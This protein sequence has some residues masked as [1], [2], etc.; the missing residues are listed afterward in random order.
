MCCREPL[1]SLVFWDGLVAVANFRSFDP[2]VRCVH[3]THGGVAIVMSAYLWDGLG[4]V[5]IIRKYYVASCQ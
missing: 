4:A 2:F 1:S 3:G 5:A